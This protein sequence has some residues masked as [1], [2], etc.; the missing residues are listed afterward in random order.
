MHKLKEILRLKYQAHLSIRQISRSLSVSLGVVSKYLQRAETAGLHWPLPDTL[1]DHQL[2]A[3]LQPQRATPDTVDVS[4]PDFIEMARELSLKGMTRQLLWEEYAQAHPDNHY[5]Y[6]RFTVLFRRWRAR[7]PLSMRQHHR[8]GE[9]LFVDYCGPTLPVINPDTGEVRDA[10]V[11]VAVLGASSYTYVEATWS[12]S[13]PDWI[14]AHVRAFTFFGGL[15]QIVVPDN[16]KS[17]VT[18]ACRYDPD[19]KASAPAHAPYLR[20]CRQFQLPT[21]GR[22]LRGCGHSGAPLQT[23]G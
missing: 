21:N 13:L 2:K 22:T 6:S 5:S 9:K 16:L 11:F 15:P 20:P 10:Q 3:L 8:V 14:G 23:Q 12:Q 7:Q 4:V 18:K 1:S 17:A 19:I